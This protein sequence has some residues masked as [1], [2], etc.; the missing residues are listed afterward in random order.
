[1]S[2]FSQFILALGMS[3]DA[4]AAAVAKGAQCPKPTLRNIIQT[5]CIF[6]VVEMITPLLGWSL[7]R[8]A[9]PLIAAYDHWVSFVLLGGLGVKMIYENLF[10]APEADFRQPETE[11]TT[12][13]YRFIALIITA[14]ATSVDSMIVG[15]SL[16]FLDVDIWLT[17]LLIGAVTAI[18][19]AIGVKLGHILGQK[20]GRFAGVAGGILLMGMGIWILVE[21]LNL[22]GISA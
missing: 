10:A 16:A 8:V 11:N 17:A 7:G 13:K 4:F 21:H 5:A 18:M 12:Q 19:A 15:V 20:A 6:G 22:W 3:A 14:F 2:L 9:E 1:M